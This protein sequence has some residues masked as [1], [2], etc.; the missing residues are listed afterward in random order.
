M[1]NFVLPV[2][3]AW[4]GGELDQ[5][6]AERG[7]EVIDTAKH[8][9]IRVPGASDL[10]VVPSTPSDV[11]AEKNG[12]SALKHLL[13][14]VKTEATVGE[15]RDKKVT[16]AQRREFL[17]GVTFSNEKK[18]TLQEQLA[19]ILPTLLLA[20]DNP[21]VIQLAPAM[22]K[23]KETISEMIF[24]GMT[25]KQ[26]AEQAGGI[27]PAVVR[28]A[29]RR[30]FGKGVREIRKEIDAKPTSR[31]AYDERELE[32][33][34]RAGF[35]A[36]QVAEHFKVSKVTIRLWC[37]RR[38]GKSFTEIRR[39]FAQE[40]FE[41]LATHYAE[42][43][44]MNLRVQLMP[45]VSAVQPPVVSAPVAATAKPVSTSTKQTM[46]AWG[47]SCPVPDGFTLE[48]DRLHITRRCKTCDGTVRHK[49]GWAIKQR[50]EKGIAVEDTCGACRGLPRESQR[51]ANGHANGRY[52]VGSNDKH[53]ECIQCHET[54][55]F[56]HGAQES[57]RSK[58]WKE[59]KRCNECHRKNGNGTVN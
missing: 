31:Q 53:I 49:V 33:R 14:I 26:I 20:D 41:I 17:Q 32:L 58:G 16:H 45:P 21:V 38:W 25:V 1:P 40:N 51:P 19:A 54:F 50:I 6:L 52:T 2:G 7:A 35:D 59:P 56:P 29:I 18:V 12:I 24:S 11:R 47:V 15:R 34:I 30:L 44:T 13:G 43:E 42:P 9:K 36:E 39:D 23:L 57:Y 5:F 27:E 4:R 37:E 8:I 28:M 10:L 3:H 46:T 55:L 22:E 48:E